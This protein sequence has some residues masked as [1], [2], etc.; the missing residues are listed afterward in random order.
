MK[1]L[2]FSKTHYLL[3]AEIITLEQ[4]KEMDTKIRERWGDTKVAD[5]FPEWLGW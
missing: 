2:L 3:K 4:Y 5:A 1:I